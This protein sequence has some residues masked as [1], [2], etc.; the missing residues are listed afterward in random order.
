MYFIRPGS[1]NLYRYG[2]SEKDNGTAITWTW[3]SVPLFMD[4]P[5]YKEITGLGLSYTPY[6]ATTFPA[7]SLMY[8]T[9]L[10]RFINEVGGYA[11]NVSE[12]TSYTSYVLFDSLY[13]RYQETGVLPHAPHF[14]YQVQ[15]SNKGTTQTD[16][17]IV[18]ALDI[19]WMWMNKAE[20]K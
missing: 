8:D 6:G 10:V 15:L 1:S 4:H 11:T 12:N 14:S 5:G 7:T 3:K 17:T 18:N 16:Y 2:T 9:L 19:Y 13:A 20:R